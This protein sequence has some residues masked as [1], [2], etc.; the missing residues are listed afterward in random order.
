MFHN[1]LMAM[2]IKKA[3]ITAA[4]RNQQALPLQTLVDRDGTSKS[5]LRVVI[6]EAVSAGIEEVCLVIVPGDREPYAQ[7]AGDLAGQLHFVQ[8]QAARL[9]TGPASRPRIHRQ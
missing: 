7:A 9:R 1:G 5:A 2:R 8:Q 4:G 3:V 6:E